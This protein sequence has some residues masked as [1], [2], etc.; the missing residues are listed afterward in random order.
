MI[1]TWGKAGVGKWYKRQAAK[2]ARR[3]A[4]RELQGLHVRKAAIAHGSN[5]NYKGT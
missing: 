3:A 1:I 5:C 4:K 2:A